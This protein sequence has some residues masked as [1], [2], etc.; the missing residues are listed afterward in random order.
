MADEKTEPRD[1]NLRQWLP[2]TVLFRGFQVAMDPKKLL[3]AAAGILVMAFGWWLLAAVF[4]GAAGN[5]PDWNDG[6]RYD[7]KDPTA[8]NRF[9][10]DRQAYNLLYQAA[11]PAD[12]PEYKDAGDIAQ[13]PED[14]E[15]IN[16]RITAANR[17]ER[18]PPGQRVITYRDQV[19]QL[20]EKPRGVL[21]TWPWFEDRGPNP[22]RM[23]HGQAGHVD[24]EG[25]Y[26][27][28]PW[29]RG[30][31][32]DWLFTKQIPV[33]LEP[34]V[35]F[36]TPIFFLLSPGVGLVN[37]LYFL[38][39]I[40]W[41]VATWSVFGGAITRMAAVQF[42]RN[43]KVSLPEALRYVWA[44]KWSYFFASLAPILI[45][46]ALAV[47]LWLFGIGNL[48][49]VFA[50]FWDGLLFPLV[51][52]GGLAMAVALF[53]MI[54][55][56]MIHATLS[57][58]GSDSFDALSRSYSYVYQAIWSYV[59]YTLVALAYGA[60]VVFFVS[61]MGSLLVYLGKW[62]MSQT[63][64]TDY[65]N[66]NPS[67]MFVWAPTSYHWRDMLTSDAPT[68]VLDP[69]NFRGWNWIGT[70]LVTVWTYLVFL[71]VIGFGYSYFWTAFTGIYL[72]MRRKVD[73]TDLDEVYLEEEEPE[74]TY[75][76]S[77]AAAPAA[78]GTSLSMVEPPSLRTAPTPPA[79]PSAPPPAAPAPAGVSTG[80]QPAE[81]PPTPP[82][83]DGNAPPA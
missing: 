36:L 16:E 67:Y 80:I 7:P 32:A 1:L 10:R 20:S 58:E 31:F 37:G 47:L 68:A 30:H 71:M 75:T 23:V 19:V 57:A 52:L 4:F 45:V 65:F 79:A 25:V 60:V 82:A 63:P 50:E 28:S 22:F 77:T 38:L 43:E 3:L 21:R 54:G 49:P 42:A 74:D 73:D 8:W 56:P 48:I 66:R 14:Y 11:A 18:V 29:E 83:G 78:P 40:L 59:W 41:T 55:W 46:A 81:P 15:I 27:P 72:L 5:K 24:A 9:Q 13:R 70:F 35:K 76:T 53:G 69:A 34:L 33:L 6:A 2:W 51:L 44:R 61:F 17:D 62:G 12:R 64:G 39:V 26:H